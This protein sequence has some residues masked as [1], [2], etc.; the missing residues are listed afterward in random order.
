[1]QDHDHEHGGSQEDGDRLD[2]Q[3]GADAGPHAT[4]RSEAGEDAPDRARHGGATA[5]DLDE[6][7]AGDDP[8]EEDRSGALGEVAE[9]HDGRPLAAQRAKGVRPAGP[10]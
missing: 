4:P 8:G 3:H 10:A 9:D 2:H 7:L 6:R 1:M 5:Q